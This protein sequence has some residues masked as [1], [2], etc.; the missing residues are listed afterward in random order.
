MLEEGVRLFSKC[1]K[2]IQDARRIEPPEHVLI[3]G[4][5]LKTKAT[6]S[7]IYIIVVFVRY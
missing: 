5:P 7:Y 3:N 1:W 6:S 4:D 2:D